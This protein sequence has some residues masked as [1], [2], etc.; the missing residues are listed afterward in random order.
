[1]TSGTR[2]PLER[3]TVTP[4]ARRPTRCDR[5]VR[6][7]ETLG[8]WLLRDLLWNHNYRPFDRYEWEDY[9]TYSS[10]G[11]TYYGHDAASNAPKYGS[12]G[13]ATQKGYSSS[14]YAKS[15]GFRD[16]QYAS[17]SGNT[18]RWFAHEHRGEFIFLIG[19]FLLLAVAWAGLVWA[20]VCRRATLHR[21]LPPRLQLDSPG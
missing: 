18:V 4:P 2:W 17:K 19:G 16:S 20:A 1:M 13:T 8:N 5:E 14:N 9:R 7:H 6:A 10:R 3:P 11:Q 15:G 12:Q 21:F